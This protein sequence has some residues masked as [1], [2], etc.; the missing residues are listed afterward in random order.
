MKNVTEICFSEKE[1]IIYLEFR[2]II[3]LKLYIFSKR[4]I[5]LEFEK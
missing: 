2:S 1:E 4:K 5:Y 3:N